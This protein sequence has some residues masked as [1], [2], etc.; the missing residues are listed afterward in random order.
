MQKLGDKKIQ[1]VHKTGKAVSGP[2]IA[3]KSFDLFGFFT[4]PGTVA[5]QK[6]GAAALADLPQKSAPFAAPRADLTAVRNWV[7]ME[8]KIVHDYKEKKA[9]L[10]KHVAPLPKPPVK[11]ALPAFETFSTQTTVSLSPIAPKLK[12]PLR[13][14]KRS[15]SGTG[16]FLPVLGWLAAGA[17]VFLYLHGATAN[18]EASER[19][20]SERDRLKRSYAELQSSSENQGAEIKWLT[21]QLR[22]SE[23]DLRTLQE[24]KA[25]FSRDLEKKYREELMRITLRYETELDTLRGT[26][27]TKDAVVGALK[28]QIQALEKILDQIRMSAVSGGVAGFF[29]SPS[30]GSGVSVAQGQIT[31]VNGR[32]GFFVMNLGADQGAR[33]GRWV[34]VS[35]EGVRLAAG[36]IDRVYPSMSAVALRDKR[37]LNVVQ[38]GDSV[39]FLS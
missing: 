10:P 3:R 16:E 2:S 25:E 39:S 22:D 15:F 38:E 29:R 13:V 11:Q 20:Q 31:A 35:R 37:F 19:L 18:R 33:S 34:A 24:N 9:A 17:L 8:E 1:I 28:A 14:P 6:T 30:Q 36:R 4:S 7:G 27:R 21:S 26:V 23:E 5:R 12:E 32:Q